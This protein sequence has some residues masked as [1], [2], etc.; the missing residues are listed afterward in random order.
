MS[1]GRR[2]ITLII[3][4]VITLI[5]TLAAIGNIFGDCIPEKQA[6]INYAQRMESTDG[7]AFTFNTI[8]PHIK[9]T[10]CMIGLAINSTTFTSRP[11]IGPFDGRYY[12]AS[13]VNGD[14]EILLFSNDLEE[15][16]LYGD[17]L[18]L[19]PKSGVLNDTKY[20][21]TLYYAPT[22]SIIGD[23]TFNT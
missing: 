13:L 4:A 18:I 22:G 14:Q 2:Q 8:E 16:I 17:H 7:I 23:Y 3:I 11:F 10:D 12:N 15:H 5:A 9:Y 1:K 6:I 19:L 21:V 20:T